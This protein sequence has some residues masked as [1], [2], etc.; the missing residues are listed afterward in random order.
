M[1]FLKQSKIVF[2]YD[3]KTRSVVLEK[4]ETEK[5]SYAISMEFCLSHFLSK[6][7]R[8]EIPRKAQKT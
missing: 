7:A 3:Q 1:T 6:A 8:T 2:R 4:K 5:V